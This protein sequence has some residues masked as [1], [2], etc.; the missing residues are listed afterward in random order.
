MAAIRSY[1]VLAHPP[2]RDL[3]AVVDLAAKICGVPMA[4]INLITDTEQHQVAAVGFDAGVCSREDS[5]CA[6]VLHAG[7]PVVVPDAREDAR[8]RDNPFVTGAIGHVRFYA[9]HQLVT[10]DGVTIGTLCVFDTVTRELDA[11]QTEALTTLAQRV[12]DVLELSLRSREL[13][14]SL[15]RV[16]AMRDELE[17]SNER[18]ASFAGQV[19]HDLK[20]PLSSL[21]LSLDLIREQLPDDD[22][23]AR[24]V[25]R[26]INGSTRMAVL[27]DHV[28]DYAKLGGSLRRERVDLSVVAAEV[29]EDL[30]GVLL[31]VDLRVEDLPTVTGDA[32]QLRAVLQN[33]LSNA[34]KFR[35]PDRT[36]TVRVSA[37]AVPGRCRVEVTDDGPGVPPG[38]HQR[39]FDLL[40]RLDEKVEGSGIGLATC[41]R[42]VSAHG[43]AIGLDPVPS[44]G[45]TFWFELPDR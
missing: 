11:V 16:E 37:R 44:G 28:L 15:S 17:R 33:L 8:F 5:M 1:D 40:T 18:L 22:A 2:E 43:G 21:S 30:R 10:H 4:T 19:S 36:P 27:I 39:I 12:V 26:A 24:L 34:A 23:S 9:A 14:V 7:G 13:S 32:T 29:V 25:D 42:I 35:R 38:D 31:D 45:T 41:R 3:A 20:T 6:A